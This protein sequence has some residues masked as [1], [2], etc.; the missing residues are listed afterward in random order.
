MSKI[1]VSAGHSAIDPGAVSGSLKESD[2]ALRLRNRIAVNLR[3][4]GADVLT[5][6]EIPA[7]NW[8]LV[9]AI[10][11]ARIVAANKGVAVEIHF[12]AGPST[13]RGVETL[14]SATQQALCQA[15]SAA[16][17]R[18][19]ESPLRGNRGHKL[20]E[21]S[22]RGRLGFCRAGGVILEVA[23][24]SNPDE[25]AIYQKFENEIAQAI[26]DVLINAVKSV[27]EHVSTSIS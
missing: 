2:L 6:G 5:D 13:A 15:L 12:N 26:A 18:F 8:P 24:I 23:F 16:V 14:G 3:A 22:H 9:S 27:P 21:E 25:M 20:P 4:L 7:E 19:T 17:A 10:R 1:F 11:R